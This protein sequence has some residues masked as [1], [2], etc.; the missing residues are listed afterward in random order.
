LRAAD[1]LF[2]RTLL[3]R[4]AFSIAAGFT[5]TTVQ[6]EQ[7]LS[8]ADAEYQDGPKNRRNHPAKAV[9]QD[10]SG[11]SSGNFVSLPVPGQ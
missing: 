9:M 7:K 6:A 11:G 5:A 10:L 4:A 2:R 8:Q 3:S 1:S